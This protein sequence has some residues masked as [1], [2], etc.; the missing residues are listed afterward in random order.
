VPDSGPSSK[1]TWGSSQLT[2]WVNTW[3]DSVYKG[4]NE[5]IHSNPDD[6]GPRKYKEPPQEKIANE[7]KEGRDRLG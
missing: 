6:F 7:A 3:C 2:Q 1:F 5:L 4:N